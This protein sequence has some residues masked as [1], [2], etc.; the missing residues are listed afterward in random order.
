MDKSWIAK[1]RN[2]MEY[3]IG[4]SK[5]L[6]FAFEHGAIENRIRCSCP[7]YGFQRWQTR[8]IAQDHLLCKPF[9]KNYVIWDFHSEKQVTE[10]SRSVDVIQE[11]L[12][13]ENPMET[14]INDAL[15]MHNN[16]GNG[17]L[18]CTEEI[19]NEESKENH[20]SFY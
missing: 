13:T 4:L 15:R 10:S 1:P 18:S 8:D 5:F 16:Q 9:P 6:D 14:M 7:K 11:I 2:T 17:E 19:L 20:S 3:S 12:Q